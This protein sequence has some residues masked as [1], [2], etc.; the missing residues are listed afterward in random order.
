[1]TVG[2]SCYVQHLPYNPMPLV[3]YTNLAPHQMKTPLSVYL[4]GAQGRTLKAAQTHENIFVLNTELESPTSEGSLSLA[5]LR[6]S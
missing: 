4:Q 5:G 2:K 1:M 6:L 3:F